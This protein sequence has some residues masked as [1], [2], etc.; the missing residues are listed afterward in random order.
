[1]A[2]RRVPGSNG[3]MTATTMLGAAIL[4]GASVATAMVAGLMFCFAHSVVPGLGALDDRGFLG[5]FQR[6]DAAIS[7]PWMMLTFL[8]SPVLTLVALLLHLPDR[9]EALPWLVLALVL[10]AATVIITG[11]IH[12]PLNG[13]IQDAAP[14]FLDVADLRSRFEDRWVRWNVVRSLTSTGSLAALSWALFVAGRAAG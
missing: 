5:A 10:T 13:A 3:S 8:G 2:W 7:N 6:I 9:S 4:V 11:V 14:G 1:M 12:L